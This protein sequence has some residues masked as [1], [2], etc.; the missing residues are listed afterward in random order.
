MPARGDLGPKPPRGPEEHDSSPP[1]AARLGKGAG[2]VPREGPARRAVSE[3]QGA[4]AADAAL[5]RRRDQTKA[6][7]TQDARRAQGGGSWEVWGRAYGR[8]VLRA[9]LGEGAARKAGVHRGA[10][11]SHVPT[12]CCRLGGG[13]PRG[14][15]ARHLLWLREQRVCPRRP[16]VGEGKVS[17]VVLDAQVPP[18]GRHCP[19]PLSSV[20]SLCLPPGAFC[21]PLYVPYV[22]T[23]RWTFGRGLC[24]L[25]LVVDY[26]LC[27]SSVFNIVLISYDRFLSVTRAVSPGT[28]RG[29]AGD[30]LSPSVVLITPDDWLLSSHVL[31][32]GWS[33]GSGARIGCPDGRVP[34]TTIR[35]GAQS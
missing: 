4:A 3:A 18:L 2:G 1:P 26:L 19:R 32:E 15:S 21:I 33:W 14:P 31:P 16:G 8:A 17:A 13:A 9:V 6:A 22:L 5:A 20:A 7:G 30:V 28:G 24:K 35:A 29:P 10:A 25:W 27:T 34:S 23:G 12:L 11:H